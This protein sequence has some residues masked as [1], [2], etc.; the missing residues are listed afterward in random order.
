[1]TIFAHVNDGWGDVSPGNRRCRRHRPSHPPPSRKG[2]SCTAQSPVQGALSTVEGPRTAGA[3]PGRGEHGAHHQTR[4]GGLD[5]RQRIDVFNV[6][7]VGTRRLAFDLSF[8]CLL[9][10]ASAVRDQ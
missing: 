6:D 2:Q 10:P 8:L 5:G 4:D 9:R 3:A 7:S 1:M